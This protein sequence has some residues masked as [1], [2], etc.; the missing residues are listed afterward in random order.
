MLAA[1]DPDWNPAWP[2]AWQ[3]HYAATRELLRDE[4]GLA[5]PTEVLPGVTARHGR[6]P[7]GG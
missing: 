1:I 6:R 4:A 3:R 5:E 2:A 7:P